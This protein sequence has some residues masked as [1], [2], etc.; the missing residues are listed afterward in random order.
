MV[1]PGKHYTPAAAK[2]NAQLKDI[3]DISK[4][5]LTRLTLNSR[6]LLLTPGYWSLYALPLLAFIGLAVFKRRE[7]EESKDTVS[8][9]RKR[10][11]KIALK[12]LVTAKMLLQENK[13]TAFYEEVSKA[14]WL[15]LSD[16]LSIPLSALSRD[17][18]KEAL[19]ARKVPESLH[20]NIENVIWECETA[21]YASG[22]SAQMESTYN[23][24]IKVISELEEVFKA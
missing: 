3:H 5:P 17:T 14:I 11:N 20:K 24:A 12:R 21:L 23:E 16:K 9:K 10:A 4:Q 6:P 1:K 15:Y 19:L 18:A 13:K 22:G 8:L 2:N 7:E